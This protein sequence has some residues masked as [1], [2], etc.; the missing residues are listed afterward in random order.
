MSIFWIVYFIA[1]AIVGCSLVAIA[2]HDRH[3]FEDNDIH[4]IQ[5]A[6]SML[7][8]TFVPILNVIVIFVAVSHIIANHLQ[9]RSKRRRVCT[10]TL[11]LDT[12][13]LMDHHSCECMSSKSDHRFPIQTSEPDLENKTGI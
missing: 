1:A 9:R 4:Y 3:E 7:V 8:M 5:I 13:G 2:W 10:P 12:I 11:E 6:G